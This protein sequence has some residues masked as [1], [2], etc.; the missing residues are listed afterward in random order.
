[1]YACERYSLKENQSKFQ[2]NKIYEK[3]SHKKENND[4]RF[5]HNKA[6]ISHKVYMSNSLNL[7]NQDLI[8]SLQY[9]K[10]EKN[11]AIMW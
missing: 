1:M 7:A 5:I 2:G 11:N 4:M 8:Q 10:K 6:K 3:K 9:S